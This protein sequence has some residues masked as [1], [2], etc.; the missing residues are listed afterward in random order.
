MLRERVVN[1]SAVIDRVIV[2]VELQ[3]ACRACVV[4]HMCVC[5]SVSI[6]QLRKAKTNAEVLAEY[7]SIRA[8]EA[9]RQATSTPAFSKVKHISL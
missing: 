3:V 1:C 5:V 8:R 6:S 2:H 7:K 4:M 9:P